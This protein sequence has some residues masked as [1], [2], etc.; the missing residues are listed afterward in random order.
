MIT[1]ARTPHV[2]ASQYLDIHVPKAVAQG[3]QAVGIDA[4]PAATWNNGDIRTAADEIIL[5]V[6]AGEGRVARIV[7]CQNAPAPSRRIGRNVDS[8]TLA[9]SSSMIRQFRQNDI[10]G[11]VRALQTLV[12]ERGGEDWQNRIE[13]LN[14]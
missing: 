7:R 4:V 6:A 3:L 5:T 12:S 14:R 9:L 10:G 1:N 13:F 8:V 2:N 11:I